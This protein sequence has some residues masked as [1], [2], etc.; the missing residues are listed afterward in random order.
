M[1]IAN[2]PHTTF[3]NLLKMK[4][5]PGQIDIH[6]HHLKG[7]FVPFVFHTAPDEQK[8][9]Y[10]PIVTDDQMVANEDFNLLVAA[11]YE[12]LGNDIKIFRA[13]L[14]PIAG[15]VSQATVH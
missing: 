4:T 3:E 7:Y 5:L 2:K 10:G 9:G 15:A 6:V 13:D 1:S 11:L 8:L 12:T 14:A